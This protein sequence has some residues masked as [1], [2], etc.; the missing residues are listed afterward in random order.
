MLRTAR[1]KDPSSAFAKDKEFPGDILLVEAAR[2][3]VDTA[4]ELSEGQIL[5]QSNNSTAGRSVSTQDR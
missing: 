1:G 3:V 4:I 5:A 2:I